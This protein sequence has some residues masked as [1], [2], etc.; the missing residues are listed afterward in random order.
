MV[1]LSLLPEAAPFE[2]IVE[3][4]PPD[5]VELPGDLPVVPGFLDV[6]SIPAVDPVDP[7][8]SPLTA[9]AGSVLK[10][11]EF[12]GGLS[13]ELSVEFSLELLVEFIVELSLELSVDARF[14]FAPL[15]AAAAISILEL[16]E[17]S[18]ELPVEVSFELTVVSG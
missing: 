8:F 9:A 1:V 10:L 7:L 13:V 15:T 4:P 18:P 6:P 14:F 3:E 2:V 16:V 11:V 5:L 12:S 17:L